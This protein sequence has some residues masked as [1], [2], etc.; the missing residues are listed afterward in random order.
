MLFRSL[1]NAWRDALREQGTLVV[2]VHVGPVDTDATAAVDVPK[3]GAWEVAEK[4]MAALE[5]G[6]D[7]VLVDDVARRVRAALSGPVDRLSQA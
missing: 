3:V 1:T 5:A 7:E 4:T 6:E 2:G